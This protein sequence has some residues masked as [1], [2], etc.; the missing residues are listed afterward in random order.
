MSI[1]TRQMFKKNMS[2]WIIASLTV[3]CFII[4]FLRSRCTEQ[5]VSVSDIPGK[6]IS[7][8]SVQSHK[9]DG[10]QETLQLYAGSAVLIDG[11]TG[12][13]LYAKNADEHRPNA[14]TTKILTCILALECGHME[15]TVTA[16]SYASKM[17][18][19]RLGVREGEKY[20]LEDM[21][22]AMMLESY[23]DAAVVIA[24]HI[25]GSV[26]EF[27]DMMNDKA[28]EIGCH[29]TY[30]I[31]PNGLDAEDVDGVHGTTASDLARIMRYCVLVS[32]C[33]EEFLRIT[34]SNSYTFTDVSENRT[35]SCVNHNTF[36]NMSEAAL[37]GKTGFT[38]DAGYCYVGAA[39]IDD[40][41]Y[42]WTLLGCGWPGNKTYKWKDS[43]SLLSYA[44]EHTAY[45][46]LTMP[47]SPDMEI[48]YSS[49][50]AQSE[51]IHTVCKAQIQ[52]AITDNRQENISYRYHVLPEIKAPVYK[53]ETVGYLEVYRDGVLID[54]ENVNIEET[55]RDTGLIDEIKHIIELAAM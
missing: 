6:H 17:P 12:D 50:S 48:T 2:I 1:L 32:P 29:Q 46:Q 36:L 8:A 35:F 51:K 33:R 55:I 31:T 16:S 45:E 41:T 42:M 19:V 28:R 40:H 53:G 26:E 7:E 39:K 10:S 27:A 14:S 43:R 30:F 11:E 20:T 5:T 34:R 25:G 44:E 4:C 37:S 9:D 18:E 22:Y 54:I 47:D 52:S 3:C 49:K 13:V 15:D 38:C 23:N 21:L 24:E